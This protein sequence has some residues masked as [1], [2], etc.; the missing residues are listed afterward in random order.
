MIAYVGIETARAR[1]LNTRRGGSPFWSSDGPACTEETTPGN[2]SDL[3]REGI[4]LSPQYLH[5]K[6][7]W[8]YS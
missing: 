6:H 8:K 2:S 5:N 3:I 4:D 1:Y 7:R